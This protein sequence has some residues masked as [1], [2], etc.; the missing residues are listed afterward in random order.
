MRNY[1]KRTIQRRKSDRLPQTYNEVLITIYVDGGY[2]FEANVLISPSNQIY[3][4]VEDL[5]KT[6][7]IKCLTEL[8]NL[9]GFIE[10]EKNLYTINFE[11]KRITIGSKSID[12]S[13]GILEEFGVK[14]I[15]ASLLFEAF[16]LNI[17]FN[18]RSLTA[19]LEASFELPFI[20]ELRY[21]K[22]RENISKLQGSQLL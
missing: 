17:I 4:N 10:N 20:K 9:V 12:I 6:L 15:E 7:K 16:G 5:F 14:Y 3:L 13:K 22:A 2:N 18:P 11:K 1:Y 19:K 21:K 8:N